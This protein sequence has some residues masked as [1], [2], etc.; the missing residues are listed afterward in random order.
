MAIETLFAFAIEHGMLLSI[1]IPFA[2]C[3]FC[4]IFR[5]A[6]NLRDFGTF[7]ATLVTFAIVVMQFRRHQ[8]EGPVEQSG[9]DMT[10]GGISAQTH[11]HSETG[12]K[13]K[14]PE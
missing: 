7:V 5:N 6:P 10:S 2:A 3:L 14:G 1:G 4:V 9:G 11:K 12:V 13:T 8:I